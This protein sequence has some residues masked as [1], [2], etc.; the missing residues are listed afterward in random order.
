MLALALFGAI[1]LVA[2]HD[3]TGV[4]GPGLDY[5][6]SGPFYISVM[7]ASAAACT[8]R[9]L[10]VERERG[11]WAA[12]AA[13]ILAWLL[14]EAWW[15]FAYYS[16]PSPPSPSPADLGYLLF[17]PL[18]IGGLALLVRDRM[19]EIDRRLWL[20]ALVSALGTAALGTTFVFD[21]VSD[22]TSGSTPE[23][24]TTLAYPLL[25]IALLSAIVGVIALTGWRPGRSWTLLLIGMAAMV[26]A[27][28]GYSFMAASYSAGN[29]TEPVYLLSACC[30]GAAAWQSPSPG[31]LR[32][33][34][35]AGW[36]GIAV[37]ISFGVI[38]VGLL[39]M[40]YLLAASTLSVALTAA[41]VIAILLSLAAGLRE[42]ESLL[43]QVRTDPLTG[44]GNHG[45][46][47]VDLEHACHSSR[48]SEPSALVLFDLDGFKLYND[49]F[50]HPAGDA[51]LKR[52]GARL[53]EAAGSD[54]GAYRTGGDEF[55]L[56]LSCPAGRFDEVTRRA[57]EAL[58]EDGGGFQVS[59]SWGRALIPEDASHP[60]AALQTADVRMYEQK[61]SGRV[62]AGS[63]VEE[64]LLQTLEERRPDLGA[65]VH[66]VAALAAR[67]GERIGLEPGELTLLRRAGELHDIGKM[68]IPD[69]ILAKPGPLDPSEREFIERHTLIGERILAAAPSLAPVA[70]IVRSSHERFDGAGYPDG[71]K[72][73]E[74]PLASRIV[75]A[76]DAYTTMTSDR[77][78]AAA[79]SASQAI[80]EVHACSGGQFDPAVVEALCAELTAPGYRSA[81]ERPRDGLTPSGRGSLGE[82]AVNET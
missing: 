53:T 2:L 55:C 46:L 42:N 41:T 50:G 8:A 24:L 68:A 52:L 48:L 13:A 58:R 78:Y 7:A 54:G 27:D 72:G 35:G 59:N 64:A 20:D 47:Q 69:A 33:A 71:L 66:S 45:R 67:V 60:S 5:F 25:D 81:W 21:Y 40:Q 74:I 49:T 16:D 38:I 4:G 77:P 75:F 80:A 19:W 23:V 51:L 29:W 44:L 10:L 6:F 30:L 1:G 18:S 63:Q 43:E 56:L 70:R 17:Y 26:A 76:C 39:L 31:T 15:T 9:A 36:R 12:L 22:R 14:A 65:H 3:F 61:D 11:A 79:R 37:P 62:S 82:V 32:P 73:D 57:T 34:V 28:I